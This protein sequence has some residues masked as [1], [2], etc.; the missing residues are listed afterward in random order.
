MNNQDKKQTDRQ[1]QNMQMKEKIS[2]RRDRHDVKWCE[3]WCPHTP[4][5]YRKGLQNFLVLKSNSKSKLM[6]M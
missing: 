1:K 6:E 5:T 4:A 2:T 3:G